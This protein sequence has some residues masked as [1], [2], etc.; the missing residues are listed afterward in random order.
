M[1]RRGVTAGALALSV[2]AGAAAGRYGA[3]RWWAIA[4]PAAILVGAA[5]ATIVAGDRRAR[6]ALSP[7]GLTAV[8]Y[9]ASFAAG[10]I[11]FW[12]ERD[13]A[14]TGIAPVFGQDDVGRALALA[15]A[16]FG[17]LVLGYVAAPLRP[18]LRVLPAP[19]RFESTSQ[20]IAILAVLL[21]FG[22]LARLEQ[23]ASGTYFHVAASVSVTTGA[24]WFVSAASQLPTLAAAFVGA[25]AFL[26]RRRGSR[27]ARAELLFYVLLAIEVAW[28]L[29]AG[30]R[31]ALLTLLLMV[32][33]VRYYGLGRRP[34]WTGMLAAVAIAC[35]VVFPLEVNY[36]NA[37]G[38]YQ[39]GAATHLRTSV[40]EL[41]TQGPAQAWQN[42]FT[43]TFTRLSSITSVA[44]ILDAGRDRIAQPPG[45][46]LLWAGESVVPRALAPGK[47]D[48]GL[49]GND[50]G[51]A[52]G[53]L[54]ASDRK[55]SI[56]ITQF[57]ELYLDFGL[58]G[59]V[60][61]MCIVGG[62]YRLLADYFA[63]RRSEPLALAVYAV[64]AWDVINLQ[65]SIV[66]VGL[67]GLIKLMLFLLLVLA[68]AGGLQRLGGSAPRPA[69]S[70]SVEP[71]RLR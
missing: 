34:T 59:V 61:G 12:V 19:P 68:A 5:V 4:L 14:V 36:R 7:L 39:H 69:R 43:A 55:T 29:P 16:S 27:D 58:V 40:G 47:F 10:G 71:A 52:Y 20:R 41:V 33:I 60:V 66:A 50:F 65:E 64:A 38:G 67:F 8:F 2:L 46:T 28:Y 70:G 62:F 35:F 57:G 53:L 45:Q 32:V 48:P 15:L 13:P 3:E 9:V 63:G 37:E 31:G 18:L 1:S 11:Y 6:D 21:A 42:G 49:F 54:G 44:A 56:A 26:A 22:W 30:S 23:V 24:S 17:A 51:R 25:Q